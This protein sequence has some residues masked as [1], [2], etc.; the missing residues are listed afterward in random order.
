MSDEGVMADDG[1]QTPIDEGGERVKCPHCASTYPAGAFANAHLARHIKKQHPEHYAPPGEK[2]KGATKRAAP[3]TRSR[4]TEGGGKTTGGTRVA[5][6]LEQRLEVSVQLIGTGVGLL[7]AY[8]GQVIRNGAKPLAQELAAWRAADPEHTAWIEYLAFDAPWFGAAMVLVSMGFPIAVHHGLVKNLP[9]L[10]SGFAPGGQ[11]PPPPGKAEENG[12]GVDL[13]AVFQQAMQDPN[14]V[15]MAQ[16]MA[17][18]GG[19]APPM[20]G[21]PPDSPVEEVR[22]P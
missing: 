12:Q 7:E 14:F 13:G 20:A 5:R 3:R 4:A 1:E 18:G 11:A 16:Q 15:A 17:Q 8:D 9:P 2:P 21:A 6:P 19:F 10:F 22:V